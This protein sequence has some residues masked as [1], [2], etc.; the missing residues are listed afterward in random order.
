MRRTLADAAQHAIHST[1]NSLELGNTTLLALNVLPQGAERPE[2]HLAGAEGT[3]V[4]LGL[5]AG[6]RQVLIKVA[7]RP[8]I[9]VTNHA[10]ICLAIPGSSG[11][12]ASCN[13]VTGG[14]KTRRFGD[15]VVAI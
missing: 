13:V 7:Q 14:E 4:Y 9:L 6:A 8:E 5:V 1:L 15:D 2:G 12:D 10:F 3:L 11:C